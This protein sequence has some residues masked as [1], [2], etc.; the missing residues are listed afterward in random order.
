MLSGYKLIT[1]FFTKYKSNIP[2][3]QFIQ[4]STIKHKS[5]TK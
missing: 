5:L 4:T 2:V 3:T 1:V